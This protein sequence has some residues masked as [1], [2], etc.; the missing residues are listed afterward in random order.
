LPVSESRRWRL[1]K[2]DADSSLD[3]VFFPESGVHDKVEPLVHSELTPNTAVLLEVEPHIVQLHAAGDREE[4]F[5]A[6][7][8]S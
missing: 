4:R 7:P 2:E 5:V 8:S 3:H 6:F 1:F